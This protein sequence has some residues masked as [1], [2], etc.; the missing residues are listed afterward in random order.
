[1]LNTDVPTK[2]IQIYQT[3]YQ[4]QQQHRFLLILI[5]SSKSVQLYSASW[6]DELMNDYAWK[7]L[8][9][10]YKCMNRTY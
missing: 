6:N 3:K 9:F 8:G 1:M 7:N 4:A 5:Y 2:S 10:I